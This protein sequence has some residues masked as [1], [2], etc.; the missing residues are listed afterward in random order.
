MDLQVHE[1]KLKQLAKQFKNM[2]RK[3]EVII[4][5]HNTVP[6]QKELYIETVNGWIHKNTVIR[7]ILNRNS[8]DT[9]RGRQDK[10][11][12]MK[13]ADNVIVDTD[14]LQSW[15]QPVQQQESQ[16][17][18]EISATNDKRQ[19]KT[20]V[21]YIEGMTIL[22][23]NNES[24]KAIV[25]CNKYYF[26]VLDFGNDHKVL[27]VTQVLTIL[28]RVT[29]AR[30][31]TQASS[32]LNKPNTKQSFT[33]QDTAYEEDRESC[34]FIGIMYN[35]DSTINR[36]ITRDESV[37]WKPFGIKY[38]LQE[39]II[40]VDSKVQLIPSKIKQLLTKYKCTL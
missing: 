12:N 8:E 15:A 13:K 10:F 36:V 21:K 40:D 23:E 18:L 34:Y 5:F 28:K 29:G 27:K 33:I 9:I 4:H 11:F 2:E 17:E 20:N 39:V 7:E 37:L 3:D 19:P 14:L 24:N 31:L 30:R 32:N 38:L 35:V 22:T 26:I 1:Q 25:E 6:D 16:V